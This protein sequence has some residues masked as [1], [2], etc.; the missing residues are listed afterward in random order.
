MN[1]DAKSVH[2]VQDGMDF[3]FSR[4]SAVLYCHVQ[5]KL[6]WFSWSHSGG[7]ALAFVL[8]GNASITPLGTGIF[9]TE[10]HRL[11]SHHHRLPIRD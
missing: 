7:A 10:E 5:K 6:A 11:S 8:P 9:N 1:F 4:D 3:L 2:E